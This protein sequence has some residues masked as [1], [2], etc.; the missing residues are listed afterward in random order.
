[1]TSILLV[2]DDENFGS[3]L[4]DYLRLHGYEVT[5][6]K[7]G[8]SGRNAYDQNSDYSICILDVMMPFQD[9]FELATYIKHKKGE[10]ALF[11][12]TARN[13]KE[14]ILKGYK[15]GADDYLTKPFDTEILLYKIKAIVSRQKERCL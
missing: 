10:Q 7:D 14:D 12:L 13:L 1:M 4:R 11:F 3:V 2:E 5:W 6:A 15:L 9:G 8:I